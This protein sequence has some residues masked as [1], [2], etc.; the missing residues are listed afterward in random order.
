MVVIR[1]IMCTVPECYNYGDCG[2]KTQQL[3]KDKNKIVRTPFMNFENCSNFFYDMM[4]SFNFVF[5][6]V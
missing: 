6:L 3:R 2:G 5:G 4:K 1:I